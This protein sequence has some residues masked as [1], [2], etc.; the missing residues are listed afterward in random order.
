MGKNKKKIVIVMGV[1]CIAF[2]GIFTYKHINKAPSNTIEQ[3]EI[4]NVE[5]NEKITDSDSSN[6]SLFEKIKYIFK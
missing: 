3:L 2:I 1:V 5:E 6:K 4:L